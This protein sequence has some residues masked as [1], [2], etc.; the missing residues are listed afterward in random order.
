MLW[1]QGADHLLSAALE[2]CEWPDEEAERC[3]RADCS[4]ALRFQARDV[5]LLAINYRLGVTHLTVYHGKLVAF[6]HERQ[7]EQFERKRLS[8]DAASL[9]ADP[10]QK[11]RLLSRQ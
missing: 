2:R 9:R 7:P 1:L 8:E 10:D 3:F 6:V 11:L 5:L 4:P